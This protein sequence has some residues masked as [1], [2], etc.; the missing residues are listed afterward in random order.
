MWVI[1][2]KKYVIKTLFFIIV[3]ILIMG[4]PYSNADTL[5]LDI[6]SDEFVE[7]FDPNKE[8]SNEV[9]AI[10]TPIST[11]IINIVEII[12]GIIQLI[13]GILAVIAITMFGFNLVLATHKPL[14]MD[15]GF[16][17]TPDD[18]KAMVDFARSLLIGAVLLFSSGT[19]VKIMLGILLESG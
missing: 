18:R 11:S 9:D 3:F 2:M 6:T 14:A 8:M 4:T 1:K 10:A 7:Q 19:F 17:K 13:G 5:H 16:G 12:L 15:L